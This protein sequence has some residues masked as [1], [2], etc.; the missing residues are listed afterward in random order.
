M[1]FK[2]FIILTESYDKDLKETL[3]K[4]PALHRKLA[5]RYKFLF[6]P[7]NELKG[8]GE[9]IG[10]IDDKNKTITVAAP[11]NYSRS[12]TILHEI[13]HLIWNGLLDDATKNKWRSLLDSTIKDH[14]KNIPP[15]SRS[16]LNQNA[17]ELFCMSYAAT[18]SKHPVET[19][20]HPKWLE[21]IKKLPK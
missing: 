7:G 6:Q 3:G 10:L 8:D 21:F 18:Y 2:A 14:K 12:F 15:K 9:H 19:F 20:N 16:A 17:E 5:S 4:I 13:G 11:W 1:E